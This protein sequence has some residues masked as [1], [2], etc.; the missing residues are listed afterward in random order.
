MRAGFKDA[1]DGTRLGALPAAGAQRLVRDS[2]LVFDGDRLLRADAGAFAAADTARGAEL[3]LGGRG[4]GAAAL[5]ER[6]GGR[7]QRNEFLRAGV[8]AFAAAAAQRRVNARN[9]V[10]ERDRAVFADAGAVAVAEAAEAAWR[11]GSFSARYR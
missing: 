4:L 6:R 9:A 5:H 8:G 3:A 10:F 1:A 2:E 7:G 11:R